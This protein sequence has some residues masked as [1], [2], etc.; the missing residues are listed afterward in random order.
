[1][2]KRKSGFTLIELLVVIAIIAIL[3]AIL[4]PIF[5][6]VRA[7]GRAADCLSN[8]RQIAKALKE[9]ASDWSGSMPPAGYYYTWLTNEK[10][11]DPRAWT[12]RIWTYVGEERD[13][14]ICKELTMEKTP[15]YGMNWRACTS[16]DYTSPE[17]TQGHISFVS[18]PTFILV[19]EVSPANKGALDYGDWDLTNDDQAD[20]EVYDKSWTDK[21]GKTYGPVRAPY[22]LRLP[23][24]HNKGANVAFGD[25]H[26][27]RI[28]EWVPGK[29][30]FAPISP[31]D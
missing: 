2:K 26:V 28:T 23:G 24:P 9:Y 25:G 31:T 14:F 15:S 19:Y 13:I 11:P 12:G 20:G 8:I 4:F 17:P 1:M 10:R 21:N 18:S 16:T 5:S 3:A 30:T 27:S 6:R 29:M 22:W 7:A